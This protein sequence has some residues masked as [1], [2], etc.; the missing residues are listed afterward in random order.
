MRLNFDDAPTYFSTIMAIVV[1]MEVV[2]KSSTPIS[3]D[4]ADFF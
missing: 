3:G 2:E 4:S 1:I